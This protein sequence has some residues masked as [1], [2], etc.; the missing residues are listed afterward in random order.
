MTRDSISRRTALKVTGAAAATAL[1]AGCSDDDNGGNGDDDGNGDDGGIAI[2]PGTEIE[3]DAQT[4]GWE[5]IAPSDIEDEQNPT[6]ILEEGEEYTMGWNEGDGSQHNIEIWDDDGEIVD[7]LVTD[8]ASEG[9]DDQ[10]LTFDASPEMAEYVC[11]PHTG[12]MIGDIVV[13]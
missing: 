9:G 4:P 12:T 1:I 3:F 7:D 10:F 11:E 2:E 13:E 8:L 5:G 6:L